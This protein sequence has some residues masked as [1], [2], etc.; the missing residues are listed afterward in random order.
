MVRSGATPTS[1]DARSESAHTAASSGTKRKRATEQ[2]F[3]AVKEGIEPGIYHSWPD[4]LTQVTGFRGA[5]C[6]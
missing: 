4:C 5:V 6:E 2:K 3:Y 1:Q